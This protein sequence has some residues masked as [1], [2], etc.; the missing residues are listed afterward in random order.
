MSSASGPITLVQYLIARLKELHTP[1]VQG[2]P[3]DY[4][5]TFLSELN[6][7]GLPWIGNANELNGAY[8]AD[9]LARILGNKRPS[10]LVTTMGVGELSAANGV[11]AC[12]ANP[13]AM[14]AC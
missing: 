7:A 2:V 11:G 12:C 14:T 8:S 6:K 10:V 4:N 9:G 3:G 5:L 1:F 13:S